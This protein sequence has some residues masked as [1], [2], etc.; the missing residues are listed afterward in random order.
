MYCEIKTVT[1]V[2]VEAGGSI[3]IPCMYERKY[4]DNLKYLCKGYFWMSCKEVVKTTSPKMKTERFSIAD[5][6]EQRIVKHFHL[7]VTA[8]KIPVMTLIIIYEVQY[9]V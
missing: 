9:L 6:T 4:Q 2:P 5:D 7:S 1:K 8:G 3:S